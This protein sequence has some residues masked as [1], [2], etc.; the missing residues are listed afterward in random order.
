M[1][2]KLGPSHDASEEALQRLAEAF[3]QAITDGKVDL[4]RLKQALGEHVETGRERYGLTWPGKAEAIKAAQRP[5]LGTLRP[6]AGEGINEDQTGNLIIEGDNLEVLKLLQKAYLGKIKMIYIDPPY[7]TGNDFVYEDNFADPLAGYLEQTGQTADG[8]RL[9]TNTET[10]GRYHSNWLSMMYP[11]VTLARNL[12]R[13][14]GV[15]FISIDDNEVAN[16][17]K[18]CDEVFG[19]ENFVA[20]VVWQK[21]Y[22]PSNDAKDFSAM[23]DHVLVYARIRREQKSDEQGFTRDLLPRTSAQDDAYSN[24]DNSLRGVWTSGDASAS[25]LR[26]SSCG[27]QNP[28]T[29]EM[30]YPPSG[31][32]WRSSR[33]ELKANLEAWGS[34]YFEK[35]DKSCHAGVS[36]VLAG[37]LKD[38]MKQANARLALGDWPELYFTDNGAGR[39]RIKRYLA[40]VQDG[41]V[42]TTWWTHEECGHNQEGTRAL[43]ELFDGNDIGFDAPKPVRLLRHILQ[44]AARSDPSALILDFFAGSGTTAQAVLEMNEEDGGNRKFILVQL[45]EVVDEDSAA[46]KAGFKNIAEI[47]KERVRR[48]I[49]K[50]DGGVKD[51]LGLDGKKNLDRGFKVYALDRSNFVPWDATAATDAASLEKQLELAVDNV[52]H[53]RS[54]EDLLAEILLKTGF[55]LN[56][57]IT[58][59]QIAGTPVYQVADPGF[60]VCLAETV[61]APLIKAIAATKPHRVVILDAAFGG[62]DALKTNAVQAFKDQGVEMFRTA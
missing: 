44:I 7:N 30:I 23:H 2:E 10:A 27:I 57:V 31:R 32:C 38:A 18:I 53:D 49:K 35:P 33:T 42:P 56:T 52:L 60:L 36:I 16:L 58:Q 54:D 41:R 3:P 47:T 39:P 20:N 19:E 45:P 5:S 29:G 25:N 26:P 13:E 21:K 51:G 9:S 43:L 59:V 28:F 8:K 6:K 17:R 46:A 24:P 15:I 37:D 62:D 50:L 55:P 12:L 4:E 14:D 1:P 48:V 61:T 22:S 11:R 34:E 40:D